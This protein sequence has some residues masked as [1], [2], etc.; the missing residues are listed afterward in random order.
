MVIIVV[1]YAFQLAK[2]MNMMSIRPLKTVEGHS[3]DDEDAAIYIDV[4]HFSS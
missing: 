2:P 4:D 3:L 1:S